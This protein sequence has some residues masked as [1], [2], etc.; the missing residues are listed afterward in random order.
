MQD[1]CFPSSFAAAQ[2][3]QHNAANR[4]LISIEAKT[5]AEE[6][7]GGRTVVQ[8]VLPCLKPCSAVDGR[9]EPAVLLARLNCL[10]ATVSEASTS[11]PSR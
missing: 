6:M 11:S 4:R 2:Q 7:E 10:S 5:Q 8:W 3:S 9:R 1:N